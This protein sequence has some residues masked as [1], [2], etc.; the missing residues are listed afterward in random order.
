MARTFLPIAAQ[1]MTALVADL[2]LA[3]AGI[4]LDS[5]IWGAPLNAL[6]QA[7]A[8][9]REYQMVLT[10][11]GAGALL[12]SPYLVVGFEGAN[13]QAV[14]DLMTAWVAAHPAVWVSEAI[15]SAL[16]A[17][18][19]NPKCAGL[20]FYCADA[21]NAAKNW[22]ITGVGG[23][24]FGD[25][26]LLINRS[27]VDQH[28]AR[29]VNYDSATAC[30]DAATTDLDSIVLTPGVGAACHYEFFISDV[31]APDTGYALGRFMA[32]VG[33]A[34]GPVSINQQIDVVGANPVPALSLGAVV[35]AGS[36]VF[37]AT[38]AGLAGGATVAWRR[39]NMTPPI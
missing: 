27:S 30:P 28:P 8:L 26:A 25:H 24:V 3:L 37:Q 32:A 23:G 18:R 19:F 21:V 17:A 20:L 39:I 22:M 10:Y 33:P 2:N 35:S 34:G 7:R 4:P 16:P 12:A 5:T 11:D 15:V 9:G 6:D 1:N 31:A 36:M 38:V 29:A 13:P 14:A